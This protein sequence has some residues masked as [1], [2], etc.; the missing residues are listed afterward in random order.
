MYKRHVF[1]SALSAINKHSIS[2][3]YPTIVNTNIIFDIELSSALR[4]RHL[5]RYKVIVSVPNRFFKRC[6]LPASLRSCSERSSD[7][8]WCS[9]RFSWMLKS[10]EGR[11]FAW[12]FIGGFCESLWSSWSWFTILNQSYQILQIYIVET[13]PCEASWWGQ[14]G[15]LDFAQTHYL[16]GSMVWGCL[17]SRLFYAWSCLTLDLGSSVSSVNLFCDLPDTDVDVADVMY[18]CSLKRFPTHDWE[19][20]RSLAFKYLKM[21]TIS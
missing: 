12:S 11:D 16:L 4:L 21:L 6:A 18:S 3:S 1:I 20:H 13:T 15:P 7:N 9:S 17:G 19:G 10:V 8:S 2:Y 14:V 5:P